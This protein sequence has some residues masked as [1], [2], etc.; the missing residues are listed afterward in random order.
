MKILWVTGKMQAAYFTMPA[1][2]TGVR[3]LPDAKSF[4]QIAGNL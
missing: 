1:T 4:L 3:P 2:Q